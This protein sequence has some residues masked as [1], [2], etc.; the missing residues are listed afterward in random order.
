MTNTE[1]RFLRGDGCWDSRAGE[2]IHLP[3]AEAADLFLWIEAAEG[4]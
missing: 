1:W 4:M 3:A 2:W